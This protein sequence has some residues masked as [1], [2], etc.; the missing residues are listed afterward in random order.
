MNQNL[1]KFPKIIN[2]AGNEQ[3]QTVVNNFEQDVVEL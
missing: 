2:D 1:I 3:F